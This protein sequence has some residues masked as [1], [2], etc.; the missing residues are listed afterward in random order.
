MNKNFGIGFFLFDRVFGTFM[1][2]G[3]AFNCDGYQAAQKKFRSVLA[4]AIK[5]RL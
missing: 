5:E 1:E 4:S 2:N 3:N